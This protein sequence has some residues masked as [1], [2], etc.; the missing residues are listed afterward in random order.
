MFEDR[1]GTLWL[2][3]IGGGLNKYNR[4]TE[5]FTRYVNIPGDPDS[6]SNNI[7]FSIYED[8]SGTLWVGTKLGGL[9]KFIPETGIFR[10]YKHDASNPRSLSDNFVWSVY[11]DST[12]SLWVGTNNGLNKFH[13]ETGTFSHYHTAVNNPNTLSDNVITSMFEDR[14][15]VLWIGTW[16]GGV[17][18]TYLR[19]KK[20]V[21]YEND[22]DDPDSLSNNMVFEIYESPAQ[23]GV[24]WIGTYS[25]GLNK[26]HRETGVFT[27]YKHDPGDPRSLSNN[28][29]TSLCEDRFGALW[30]GTNGG[31]LN[32]FDRETEIF[33]RFK[34]DPGDPHA[35]KDNVVNH[36]YEDRRGVLWIG[37]E[38][39]GTYTFDRKNQHFIRFRADALGDH[40]VMNYFEDRAG[41][42]WFGTQSGGIFKYDPENK[43]FQNYRADPDKPG[44]LNA[45][46]ISSI[47]EDSSGVLWIGTP[48]GLNKFDPVKDNFPHYPGKDAPDNRV[49]GGILE[50]NSGNLWVTCKSGL[51][52]F[53][54]STGAFRVY[55]KSDGLQGKE[56]NSDVCWK[57]VTGEMYFGG[58]NGVSAFFP[59]EIIDDPYAPPVVITTFKKFYREVKLEKHIS[60]IKELTLSHKDTVFSF[61]FAALSFAAPAKNQYACTLEG[62]TKEWIYL[63]TKHDFTITSLDPGK[64][65]FRAKAANHD[66][67]WNE[68]GTALT[69]IITPPLWQ[70]PWFLFIAAVCFA[71][72]SYLV[73]NFTRKHLKLITFWKKKNF[74]G[75]YK[76]TDR[77]GSGGMGIVY[78]AEHVMGKGTSGS[79]AVKV[80]REELTADETQRKRF[81][82]EALIV[83]RLDH[84]NIVKVIERGEYNNQLFL[85]MELL[86]GQSLADLIEQGVKISVKDAVIIMTQLL[87]AVGQIHAKSIVHRDLKPENIMLVEKGENKYFVKL[88]D[89]GLA[90]DQSLT[91][92]TET[93]EILGTVNYLP[94][95][96]ISRHTISPA[97]DIYSL[98]VIFY[99][100]LTLEKPFLGETPIDIIKS[101]L[102]KEPVEPCRFRPGLPPEL[103]QLIIKLMSKEPEQRPPSSSWS[104]WFNLKTE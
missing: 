32:K 101:I 35:L 48:E 42:F 49:I 31:G 27:H 46:W 88:L 11:E 53:N 28:S 59:H 30:I 14:S 77:I 1:S 6:L 62:L 71:V 38:T 64:Y 95:E 75:H 17:N 20:F 44:S 19:K 23:P 103:N 99:E 89:F 72:L 67:V 84:P 16:C 15:G 40:V 13:R 45:D 86:E 98:G 7:I 24:I 60:E 97:G 37:T 10:R 39:G 79:F 34:A 93:G 29:V 5:S 57:S 54:P 102:E 63:G 58:I 91:R 73:I 66:G 3:T 43:Q 4:E 104:S 100:M 81:L 65:V 52:K 87:D 50:D 26:F 92:L 56:F 33:T 76:I 41:G 18:K 8:R 82:N 94:P 47:Y 36:L 74:I 12:G 68:E 69:L 85:A 80:I 9:N 78:K 21:H 55:G 51:A 70:T 96:R 2:G 83:D 90:R 25:G 61:E 22:P